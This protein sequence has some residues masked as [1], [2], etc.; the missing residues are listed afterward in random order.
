[1]SAHQTSD[2][3]SIP[4]SAW[5]RDLGVRHPIIQA[6][7]AGT[8]TPELAAAVSSAGALGSIS[9]A[10]S[11]LQQAGTM[12][13][14]TRELTDRPFNVNVFCHRPAAHDPES[15]TAWL[16]H[17]RPWFEELGIGTPDALSDGYTSLVAP[18]PDTDDED[19][20]QLQLLLEHRP[21]V[22]SLHLGLPAAERITALRNAGITVL[23]S[24]TCVEEAEQAL[25][26]G[27]D[28]LVAQGVEAGGHRGVF[29]P[30][31]DPGVGVDDLV[32]TVAASSQTPVVAAGGLMDGD[33]VARMI[34]LGASAAQLGTAF[35]PCPESA[36]DER[37]R[38]VLA[39]ASQT[40]ITR[41]V[42]GRPARG[43]VNRFMTEVDRP[44]RPETPAF[45]HPYSAGKALI[46]GAAAAG[47]DGFGSHWAGT[48]VARAR[49]L[50][51]ADLVDVLAQELQT[52]LLS[53]RPQP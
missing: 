10:S 39:G 49:A 15:D 37:Y 1:M 36:A 25:A 31:V 8:A 9:I 17:L 20:A 12:I 34:S 14:R 46:A 3:T 48:G 50:P 11:S 41:V 51:A 7:M 33:D 35:V 26:A 28:V 53:S 40:A 5:W 21:D 22:V 24:V 43:V 16:G 45:A 32:P 18:R 4:G 52:A 38:R 19:L 6:P 44:G 2:P 23:A 30:A 42:S 47:D 27:V 13:E 29:D